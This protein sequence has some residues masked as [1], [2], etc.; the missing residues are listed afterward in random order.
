LRRLA[1][2]KKF[3][4]LGFPT[5][6]LANEMADD[7]LEEALIAGTLVAKYGGIIVMSDFQGETL[8]PS[9]CCG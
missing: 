9:W 2:Q 8:F 5:I 1:I 7:P 4:A 3:R 6:I